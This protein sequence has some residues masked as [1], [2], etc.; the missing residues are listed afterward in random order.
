MPG[1]RRMN[2]WIIGLYALVFFPLAALLGLFGPGRHAAGSGGEWWFWTTSSAALVAAVVT[3]IVSL[4]KLGKALNSV[5]DVLRQVSTGDFKARIPSEHRQWITQVAEAVE[6]MQE[7]LQ[8]RLRELAVRRDQLRTV[9]DTLAEGVIAVD[10]NQ[11]VMLV[12]DSACALFR[13][14]ETLA[15][16]RPLWELVRVPQIQEW[17][18][19]SLRTGQPAGGEL[20]ILTPVIRVLS[21]RVAGMDSPH[22]PGAVVVASDIS[23]LRRLESVRQEFVANASHELKTPLASIKACVETLLDGALDDPEHRIG[24]LNSIEEQADRLDRIVRDMLSL[25]RVETGGEKFD[26]RPMPVAELVAACTERHRQTAERRLMR[27]VAEP[28]AEPVFVL[29]DAEAFDEILDNLLDN[30]L[31]YTNSGGTISVRWRADRQWCYV[32]VEDSG[33]GIPQNHLPRIFERFYRVD[34]AR[35]RELGGT[36][37]GLSI[38]KHLVQ[39]LSGVVSVTS[40]LGKGTIFTIQLKLADAPQVIHSNVITG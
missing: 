7:E 38:V 31:K 29:A 25:T 36:G 37:L 23:Q 16:G 8:T 35:S 40:K 26:I 28:P 32:E 11:R 21:V 13:F 20:E 10:E 24:F 9:V 5:R 15:L 14:Q 33:I 34:R 1:R 18:A 30:A 39:Q 6:R 2:W 3:V 12:N 17:V 27:L 22:S 4:R 19:Q